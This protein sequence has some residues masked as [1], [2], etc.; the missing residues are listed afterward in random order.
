MLEK[1]PYILRIPVSPPSSLTKCR[2]KPNLINPQILISHLLVL[3]P[4]K[5]L[6]LPPNKDR[7][8]KL[9][10][11]ANHSNNL[12]SHPNN[13]DLHSKDF[14]N[15]LNNNIN[16]NNKAKLNFRSK[17]SNR[18]KGKCSKHHCSKASRISNNPKLRNNHPFRNNKTSPSKTFSSSRLIRVFKEGFKINKPPQTLVPK[19]NNFKTKTLTRGKTS[20]KI[21]MTINFNSNHNSNNNRPSNRFRNCLR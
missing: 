2:S 10:R 14:K 4:N 21:K 7:T 15:S 5:P 1:H 6:L 19:V 17:L 13:K 12:L 11:E 18:T 8:P 20:F 9:H 3:S 16:P